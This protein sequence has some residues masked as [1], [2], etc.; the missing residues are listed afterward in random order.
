LTVVTLI[1][2]QSILGF[3]EMP[4]KN[5][6][7]PKEQLSSRERVV[8]KI[9]GFNGEPF[10]LQ[11]LNKRLKPRMKIDSLRFH[12]EHLAANLLV[13]KLPRE[14]KQPQVYREKDLLKSLELDAD[15]NGMAFGYLTDLYATI[16]AL[17]KGNVVT[18]DDLMKLRK[19]L[20]N[21]IA[22]L[23]K[24]LQDMLLLHDCLDLWKPT[25]LVNRLGFREGK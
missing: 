17:R 21:D 18:S 25:T 1:I 11:Q 24:E 9:Q 7:L 22:G 15:L 23:E 16:D 2:A 12:V 14:G 20:A 8:R 3:I 19:E 13:E 10:T 4:D 6:I 5:K